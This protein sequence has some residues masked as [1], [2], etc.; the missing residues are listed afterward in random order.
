MEHEAATKASNLELDQKIL[1]I[2]RLKDDLAAKEEELEFTKEEL[3]VKEVIVSEI[4]EVLSLKYFY[5]SYFTG[6][7]CSDS[8]GFKGINCMIFILRYIISMA[9]NKKSYLYCRRKRMSWTS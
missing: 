7:K 9:K 2:K 4:R 8:V 6:K 5:V 1:S 3:Q